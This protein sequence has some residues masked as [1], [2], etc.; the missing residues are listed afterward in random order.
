MINDRKF[1]NIKKFNLLDLK[2]PI[3]RN[4]YIRFS[5]FEEKKY[6]VQSHLEPK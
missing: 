6:K 1:Y 5:N 4:E 2:E 3:S